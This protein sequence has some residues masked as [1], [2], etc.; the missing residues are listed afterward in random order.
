MMVVMFMVDVELVESFF[1]FVFGNDDLD[2]V[3]VIGIYSELWDKIMMVF[4]SCCVM[5][6][7]E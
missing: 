3:W 2:V 4:E 7:E 6:E 5:L 1:L